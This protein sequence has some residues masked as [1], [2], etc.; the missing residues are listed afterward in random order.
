MNYDL[1]LGSTFF[2]LVLGILHWPLRQNTQVGNSNNW[3]L[4]VVRQTRI[5]CK[6]KSYM[7]HHHLTHN[8]RW[9]KNPKP[10][11]PGLNTYGE[12]THSRFVSE[13]WT[14]EGNSSIHSGSNQAVTARRVANSHKLDQECPTPGV[15]RLLNVAMGCE[16]LEHHPI[17]IEATRPHNLVK[18][19]EAT[20]L[21]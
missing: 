4:H 1:K 8:A 3:E 7:G 14:L 13:V 19:C 11:M 18:N 2:N 20:P 21:W 15:T 5:M 6:G 10:R 17:R 9:G 16:G 12:T